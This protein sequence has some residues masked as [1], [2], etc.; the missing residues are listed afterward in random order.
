MKSH[1]NLLYLLDV[2]C[3]NTCMFIYCSV[4]EL[5]SLS[6]VFPN[7]FSI[8][9]RKVS[10]LTSWKCM[11]YEKVSKKIPSKQSTT[12]L[13]YNKNRFSRTYEIMN[14]FSPLLNNIFICVLVAFSEKPN[15]KT[16]ET[17]CK[18]IFFMKIFGLRESDLFRIY[19]IISRTVIIK[20]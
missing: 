14:G 5:K 6:F 7:K 1:L 8:F 20:N 4:I 16:N 3:T 11:L 19:N 15:K 12:F 17:S 13:F 10:H 18:I 9:R 2:M